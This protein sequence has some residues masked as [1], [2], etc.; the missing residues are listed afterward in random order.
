MYL[1]RWRTKHFGSRTNYILIA[2]ILTHIQAYTCANKV[3]EEGFQ[4]A[5]ADC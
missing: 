4:R 1:L 3:E 2:Y 5:M